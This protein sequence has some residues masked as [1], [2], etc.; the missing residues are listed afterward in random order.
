MSY[1]VPPRTS[2]IE[3]WGSVGWGYA[4]YTVTFTPAP[5]FN[6]P[7]GPYAP[8]SPYYSPWQVLS[9][10]VLDPTVT[11]TL[12]VDTVSDGTMEI[13]GVEFFTDK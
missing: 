11:Y 7:N 4:N 2:F 1:K 12:T 5:P 3:L 10:T 13:Y 8:F 9:F 6:P